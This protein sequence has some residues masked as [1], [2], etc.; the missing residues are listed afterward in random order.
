MRTP[1]YYIASMSDTTDDSFFFWLPVR[2]IGCSTGT[3]SYS[4]SRHIAAKADVGSIT[5]ANCSGCAGHHTW[6]C[7][8][9]LMITSAA[10]LWAGWAGAAAG[11][12]P[13][14]NPVAAAGRHSPA[15]T[16]Q[17]SARAKSAAWRQGFMMPGRQ[18]LVRRHQAD[19]ALPV[20]YQATNPPH[21]A[22]AVAWV[23]LQ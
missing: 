13:L 11:P 4:Y 10:H 18:I 19:A 15:A 1:G 22:M 20:N 17:H 7:R 6:P 12:Q 16:L 23:M 3:A 21:Q 9:L 14:R 8:T 2:S 5:A